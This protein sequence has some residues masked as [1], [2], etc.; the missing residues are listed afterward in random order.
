MDILAFSERDRETERQG[1]RE[2]E[3]QRDRETERQREIQRER[4]RDRETERQRETETVSQAFDCSSFIRTCSQHNSKIRCS[5]A[6]S[7]AACCRYNNNTNAQ[8]LRY[9]YNLIAN[10]FAFINSFSGM[11]CF[12]NKQL[13]VTHHSF[14]PLYKKKCSC[15]ASLLSVFN[16]AAPWWP[17]YESL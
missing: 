5:R 2:T 17:T 16:L 4:D 15:C 1:E 14:N 12:E 6:F 3:R 10:S 7:P 8:K 13:H 9:F 11:N